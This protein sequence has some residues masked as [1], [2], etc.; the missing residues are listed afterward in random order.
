MS[1]EKSKIDKK[2]VFLEDKFTNIITDRERVDLQFFVLSNR[3]TFTNCCTS[4]IVKGHNR[5]DV[6][7]LR[8][9]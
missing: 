3:K 7:D 1:S 2:F 8:I 4:F 9:N 6:M 5:L